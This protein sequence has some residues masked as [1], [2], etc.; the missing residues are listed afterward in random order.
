MFF[1]L[2]KNWEEK[3]T[4]MLCNRG[5]FIL[6][7]M[8]IT[9]YYLWDGNTFQIGYPS[10][11]VFFSPFFFCYYDC[12]YY[13]SLAHSST[14]FCSFFSFILLSCLFRCRLIQLYSV[15]RNHGVLHF[16]FLPYLCDCDFFFSLSSKGW[17]INMTVCNIDKI[18]SK[19]TTT[20]TKNSTK[21]KNIGQNNRKSNS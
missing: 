9:L 3:K 20:I 6:V 16:S 17:V 19:K 1:D 10:K 14:L 5:R 8:S 7:V 4:T 15:R 21:H 11:S 12:Y 2:H 13:L 18:Y